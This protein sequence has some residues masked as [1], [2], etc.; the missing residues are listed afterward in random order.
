MEIIGKGDIWV[1]GDLRDPRLFEFSLRV[2]GKAGEL[3]Y[4]VSSKTAMVFIGDPEKNSSGLTGDSPKGMNLAR[5]EAEAI[6]HGADHVFVFEHDDLSLP[7]PDIHASILADTVLNRSPLLVLFALTDFGRELAAR[8][9]RLCNAGLIADCAD[10]R[11]EDNTIIADCPAWGGKFLAEIGFSDSSRTGFATVSRHTVFTGKRKGDPGIVKRIPLNAVHEEAGIRLLSSAVESS[12]HR[13]LE[14]AEIV[15]VGG[16]GLGNTKGFGLVRELAAAL[17]GETG[18]TRPPVL[19]HW[20]AEERLIGQTGKSVRP[21]LLF[22]IG[23]SGAIQ[24]TAGITDAETIVAINRDPNASIF[25]LSDIGIVA[26]ANT[27]VPLL[28]EKLQK[29]VM[30]KL[31]DALWDHAGSGEGEASGF[32]AQVTKL[33]QGRDWTIETLAEAT[34]ESPEFISQVEADE[35]SPPVSFLVRLSNA[36]GIDPG[37]FLHK[38]EKEILKDQR[39]RAYVRRT[40]NYSYQTLTDGTE[41]DHLQAFMVTIESQHAHKPVA[42]KH[43]GEEFIFVMEGAL[44]FTLGKKAHHLK[45]GE[46]IHFN[47]NIPHKLKSLS[48]K[49]TRCLVILYTI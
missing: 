49:P 25:E 14:D 42:Y 45:E 39:H 47:S 17:G 33:R 16:A 9:A 24:Y 38:G 21:K 7:R 23:T 20:V 46:S 40:R 44:E 12:T 5:C 19:Q 8:T 41:H 28:T 48:N 15:V 3:A 4:S 27:F 2:L 18:A 31:A 26:D 32:G 37:V 36:L 29:A 1:Y 30:R 43:E 13:K 6:N 35:V 22:S 11:L 10:L 34:G